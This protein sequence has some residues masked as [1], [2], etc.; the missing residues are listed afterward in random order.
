MNNYEH[1]AQQTDGISFENLGFNSND[2]SK[3]VSPKHV[4]I[5]SDAVN[6]QEQ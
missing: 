1:D 5:D 6:N 4:T 3:A 2:H